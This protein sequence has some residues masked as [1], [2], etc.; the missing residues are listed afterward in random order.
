MTIDAVLWL[1]LTI[2]LPLAAPYGYPRYLVP[3]VLRIGGKRRSV[4]HRYLKNKDYLELVDVGAYYVYAIAASAYASYELLVAQL[5]N[6]TTFPSHPIA[7]IVSIVTYA[8]VV[9]S[10]L[11]STAYYALASEDLTDHS[12]RHVD[13]KDRREKQSDM[14]L[15]CFGFVALSIVGSISTYCFTR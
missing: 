2:L 10:V 4:V 6:R 14:L 1:V 12:R 5:G 15:I 13:R 7:V 3:L 8:S 9:A 11:G